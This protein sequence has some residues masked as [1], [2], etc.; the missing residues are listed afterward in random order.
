MGA[1]AVPVLIAS[2]VSAPVTVGLGKLVFVFLCLC[3]RSRTTFCNPQQ[4]QLTNR[5]S[6]VTRACSMKC[7]NAS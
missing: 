3:L 6:S 4:H 5:V 7:A 2:D 1:S